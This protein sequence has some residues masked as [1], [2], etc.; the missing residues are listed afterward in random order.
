M[1]LRQLALSG[2][3][4]L[5][6]SISWL[7]APTLGRLFEERTNALSIRAA[8]IAGTI[9]HE[10]DHALQIGIPI[11]RLEGVADLFS[12]HGKRNAAILSIS[13]VDASGNLRHRHDSASASGAFLPTNIGKASAEVH[14]ATQ[15]R[16]HIEIRFAIG[17]NVDLLVEVAAL[18]L[19]ISLLGGVISL[20][21]LRHAADSG[22]LARDRATSRLCEAIHKGHFCVRIADLPACN[23]DMRPHGLARRIRSLKES[24]ARLSRMLD[25]LIAT[26]PTPEGCARLHSLR[27]SSEAGLPFIETP[28]LRF[29]ARDSEARRQLPTLLLTTALAAL[30]FPLISTAIAPTSGVLAIA[31]LALGGGWMLARRR[32]E[33]APRWQRGAPFAFL[34]IG[35]LALAPLPLFVRLV[36]ASLFGAVILATRRRDSCHEVHSALLGETLG[37]LAGAFLSH[38]GGAA[39]ALFSATV[40]LIGVA[41]SRQSAASNSPG[42][43]ASPPAAHRHRNAVSMVAAV[44]AGFFLADATVS[45]HATTFVS[46]LPLSALLLL[47]LVPYCLPGAAMFRSSLEIGRVWIGLAAGALLSLAL[48]T[49]EGNAAEGLAIITASAVAV[50]AFLIVFTRRA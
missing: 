6:L 28:P 44:M 4:L 19:A 23:F 37:L 34:A 40:A 45:L 5:L 47:L 21:C 7:T 25:S 17:H 1:K 30:R 15:L 8:L 13:F 26:E 14:D 36:A 10:I 41:F 46:T 24:R 29:F 31:W 20:L 9:A 2:F 43:V 49:P 22:P 39:P 27:I 42:P 38:L 18:V 11:D 35:I 33:D 16:G 12:Q 3:L 32:L 50:I 48:P